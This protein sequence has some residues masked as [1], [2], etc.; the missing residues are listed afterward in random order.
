MKSLFLI[1]ILLLAG[2]GKKKDDKISTTS[3]EEEF[4]AAAISYR[5]T[6]SRSTESINVVSKAT[7]DSIT[8]SDN[9]NVAGFCLC[10]TVGKP[11]KIYLRQ[12][13]W[14]KSDDKTRRQLVFHELGHCNLVREHNSSAINIGNGTSS[15]CIFPLSIM[16]PSMFSSGC[17]YNSTSPIEFAANHWSDYKSQLFLGDQAPLQRYGTIYTPSSGGSGGGRP[18]ILI[19]KLAQKPVETDP[20]LE[21]ENSNDD[22]L[23]H[24]YAYKI[25]KIDDCNYIYNDSDE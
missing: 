8:S 14:D 1:L 5:V 9:S 10:A 17:K 16:Y 21:K 6:Q 24:I 2:C 22:F 12:D 25:K 7:M 18:A 23:K 3:I 13:I 11:C 4:K 19:N 20:P 15:T